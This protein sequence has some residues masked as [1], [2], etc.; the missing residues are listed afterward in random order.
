MWTL[1]MDWVEIVFRAAIV[2]VFL[3]IT[4][5]I[6][7]K[8]HFAELAPFDFLLLLI[9]SEAVQ[10]ALIDTDDSLP[11]SFISILTLILLNVFL[12]KLTFHSS[13]A[14]RIIE[15]RPK[16][17]I[18]KGRIDEVLRRKETISM[19]ELYEAIR[20]KGVLE[21]DDVYLATIETNG[22]ISIIRKEDA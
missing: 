10:N 8:K 17:L 6:W 11:A 9:I 22:K 14:E 13:L 3:L 19:Q 7:G 5:R 21:I 2:F 18:E 15:G 4:F 20:M 16:T 1:K 12:G